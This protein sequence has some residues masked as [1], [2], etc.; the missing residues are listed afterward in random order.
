MS[1][2][3][4]NSNLTEKSWNILVELRK[5]YDFILIGGWAVYLHAQQQKSKD[6][7]IVV[8]FKELKK[9]KTNELSLS[10]NDTL[11]KYE[12]KKEEIDVDIYLEYYSKLAIPAERIKDY[13]VEIQSFSV[14]SSELLVILKQGAY[15]NI[16]DSIKGQKDEIDI[17]SLLFFSNFDIKK[18]KEMIKKEN[19]PNYIDELIHLIKLFKN[20]HKLGLSPREFKIRKNKILEKFKN[21]I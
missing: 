16:R 10:K 20:Y 4:W 7:D 13:V 12:I 2:Q 21:I 19:M 8:D 14:A 17:M 3:F 18:Y 5:E 9:L 6:I 11:K 1:E 15:E